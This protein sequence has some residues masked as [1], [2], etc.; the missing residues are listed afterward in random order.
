[1]GTWVQD[2]RDY[3]CPGLLGYRVPRTVRSWSYRLPGYRMARV[4]AALGAQGCWSLG[5]R[6]PEVV[7]MVLRVKSELLRQEGT[8]TNDGLW[9]ETWQ[10]ARYGKIR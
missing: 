5:C 4:D 3:G 7:S 9:G 2:D 6:A 8:K 1:M 10:R